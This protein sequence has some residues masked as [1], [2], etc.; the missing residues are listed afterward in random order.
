VAAVLFKLEAACSLG[1][2]K[3][4]P[5]EKACEWND[6][7]R[8]KAEPARVKDI[9]FY[10]PKLGKPKPLKNRDLDDQNLPLLNE[11]ELQDFI[12]IAPHSVYAENFQTICSDTDSASETE[13]IDI[14]KYSGQYIEMY[15]HRTKSMT[16]DDL[17]NKIATAWREFFCDNCEAHLNRNEIEQKTLN[18][19]SLW[20]K[21]R[22]GRITAT[23]AHSI[24]VRRP[25]S[26]LN[27]IIK[28]VMGYQVINDNKSL[29]L[30]LLK[31]TLLCRISSL[32]NT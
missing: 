20:N 22:A 10:K 7:S 24:R 9:L 32:L 13:Q 2:T 14:P 5:T 29:P 1:L 17:E 11:K 23:K 19:E 12:K 25:N 16:S 6:Y 31:K 15:D 21:L 27:K 3:I 4:T 26:D 8:S 18:D 30:F 28:S